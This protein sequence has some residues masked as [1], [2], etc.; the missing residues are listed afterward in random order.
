VLDL[1][2]P[3]PGTISKAEATDA[4]S[5]FWR[6]D[7]DPAAP[8]RD[9]LRFHR[10][11]DRLIQ[12]S[13]DPDLGALAVA[14]AMLERAIASGEEAGRIPAI[15][16]CDLSFLETSQLQ[17]KYP[18]DEKATGKQS[19]PKNQK[20]YSNSFHYRPEIDPFHWLPREKL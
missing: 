16:F 13:A 14:S 6:V 2:E 19:K 9:W 3:V 12:A 5:D 17:D 1:I 8:D 10:R 4:A 20:E 18:Y 15:R 7:D 11:E